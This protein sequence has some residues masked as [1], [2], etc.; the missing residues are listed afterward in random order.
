V[1][2]LPNSPE[3]HAH[4]KA[5]V[6]PDGD[7]PACGTRNF[8][9]LSRSLHPPPP[10]DGCPG[11]RLP[12]GCCPGQTDS[13]PLYVTD[14][15]SAVWTAQQV[16]ELFPWETAPR[17]VLRDRD[18]VYGVVVSSRL[19]P[20][21]SLSVSYIQSAVLLSFVYHADLGVPLEAALEMPVSSVGERI[22]SWTRASARN[23]GKRLW[24]WVIASRSFRTLPCRAGS[25][26][27]RRGVARR[28]RR[29]HAACEPLDGGAAAQPTS[30]T[31][32]SRRRS[33]RRQR[34]ATKPGRPSE[35][36]PGPSQRYWER[37]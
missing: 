4:P 10:R 35:G 2:L 30:V 5:G 24:R 33:E 19:Q 23:A 15:P 7:S 6:S 27:L 3:R 13:G 31:G 34:N 17:Y 32:A 11:A 12:P 25:G 21:G 29:P 22:W 37:T 9:G 16:V 26:A 14:V 8:K 20:S 36:R 28:G 18:A 1:P